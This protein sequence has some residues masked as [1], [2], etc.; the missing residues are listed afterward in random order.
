MSKLC[1]FVSAIT[2]RERTSSM[3]LSSCEPNVN[4]VYLDR[5]VN[6][7]ANLDP[8]MWPFYSWRGEAPTPQIGYCLDAP[9]LIPT[10]AVWNNP[11]T[12]IDPIEIQT[13]TRGQ[14]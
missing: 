5:E 2:G 13:I 14:A 9:D 11:R 4:L 3:F 6:A 10:G 1:R 7:K 8:S 12:H